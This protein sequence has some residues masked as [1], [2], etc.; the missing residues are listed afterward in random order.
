MPMCLLREGIR[1]G[2]LLLGTVRQFYV[3]PGPRSVYKTGGYDRDYA[4]STV[5]RRV[6]AP[7]RAIKARPVTCSNTSN[8][9][10]SAQASQD[11]AASN[12]YYH[13]MPP[14]AAA[15]RT[16]THSVKASGCDGVCGGTS[17]AVSGCGSACNSIK[18]KG[19]A[20]VTPD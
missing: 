8:T 6:G 1:K 13:N 18:K 4:C 17:S 16:A 3:Q 12:Y 7:S 11:R 5:A 2:A 19:C 14:A 20:E 15:A 9:G 10:K